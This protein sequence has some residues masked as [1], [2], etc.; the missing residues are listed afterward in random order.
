MTLYGIYF[1]TAKADVKPDSKVQLDEMAKL[2]TTQKSLE[3]YI[4]GHTDNQGSL[5]ANLSLSQKRADAIVAALAKEYK[6]DAKR[7]QARGAASFSP[8]ASNSSDAGRARNR[9]VEL[10]EQ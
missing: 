3:V 8:V 1:D 5:D 7:M 10:V 4:V 2:L 9:R 6:I